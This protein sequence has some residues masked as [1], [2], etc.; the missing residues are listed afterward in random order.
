MDEWREVLPAIVAGFILAEASKQKDMLNAAI[1]AGGGWLVW[2]YVLQPVLV[3]PSAQ[4]VALP[5]PAPPLLEEG[6]P[7]EEEPEGLAQIP[8]MAVW[9]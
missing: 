5:T 9:A 7:E 2:R 4:A 8:P 1:I 6:S 3:K